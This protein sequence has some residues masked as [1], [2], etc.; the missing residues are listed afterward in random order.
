MRIHINCHATTMGAKVPKFLRPSNALTQSMKLR[1]SEKMGLRVV[2][3]LKVIPIAAS[4]P[5]VQTHLLTAYQGIATFCS[6][7]FEQVK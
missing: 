1:K 6:T 5:G 4:R 2:S 7:I 3:S